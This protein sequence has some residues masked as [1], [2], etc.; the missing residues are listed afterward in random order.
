V[1]VILLE[2][3]RKPAAQRELEAEMRRVWAELDR[4]DD[5]AARM[6][7]DHVTTM[8]AAILDRLAELPTTT[9]DGAETF[10][11]TAL[12]T[13][14]ADLDDIAARFANRY[15]LDLG[16]A[17]RGTAAFSDEAHRAALTQLARSSGVP[18]SLISMSTLGLADDQVA[19]AVLFNQSAISTVSQA[20]VQAVNKEIQAVVF[21]GQSRWDAV[22]NIR[23]ALST[24]GKSLGSL[25]N[26]ALTI[27]RTGMIAVLNVA[28]EHSYRQAVEEL[29]DLE[30]SWITAKDKRVDPI[31]TGLSG[32][33]KKPG[34]RFPGG[35]M[36]PPAHPRCRCRVVA[37]LPGWGTTAAPAKSL[38]PAAAPGK[39][40]SIAEAERDMKRHY[41]NITFDFGGAHLDTINPSMA[42]F[43]KLAQDWPEVAAR[44]EYVGTTRNVPGGAQF[45]QGFSKKNENVMAYATRD[46]KAIALNPL[47]FGDPSKLA[48][49]TR[50]SAATGWHPKGSDPIQSVMIHEFGHQVDNWSRSRGVAQVL[51]A[52]WPS[53]IGLRNDMVDR[54]LTAK[55]KA[56][57]N[58]AQYAKTNKAEQFAELFCAL[59]MQAKPAPIVKQF[60]VLVDEVI[61]APTLATGTNNLTWMGRGS[62]TDEER[63]AAIFEMRSLGRRLGMKLG[64]QW[65]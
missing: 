32:A 2:A 35:Y 54:W 14:A 49:A 9:V 53:G 4:M 43:H 7:L 51:P 5:A 29:P 13:F 24:T 18:P 38:P 63:E 11:S 37:Y 10:Q 3:A 25:T 41:S 60:R 19:A 44:L 55:A 40:S 6:V 52:V 61:K 21:G 27:E 17:M 64:V 30:V 8:R 48:E 36:A 26:R 45:G 31:C 1:T 57:G 58:L 34:E 33:R 65:P 12:R 23:A 50:V 59:E 15:S 46:G 16:E 62:M 47:Y 39:F 22:K 56:G 20:V 42:A 28:A